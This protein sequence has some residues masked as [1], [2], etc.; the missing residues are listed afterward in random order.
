MGKMRQIP[1]NVDRND[2]NCFSRH[3]PGAS[4]ETCSGLRAELGNS[5]RRSHDF[6]DD[7]TTL[8][9]V[10]NPR[11]NAVMPDSGLSLRGLLPLLP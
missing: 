8:S 1:R 11:P 4:R 10:S 7:S 6:G 5:N 3:R 9:I 2:P